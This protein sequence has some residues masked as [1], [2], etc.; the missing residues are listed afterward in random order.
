M[1]ESTTDLKASVWK[2]AFEAMQEL[3]EACHELGD[4]TP[5]PMNTLAMHLEAILI[6]CAPVAVD[7]AVKQPKRKTG[8]IMTGY[9]VPLEA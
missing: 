3:D 1:S 8:P 9:E 2:Y 5:A 6:V 4:F 7:A